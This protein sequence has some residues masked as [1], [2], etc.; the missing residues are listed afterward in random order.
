VQAFY[1]ALI[2][3]HLKLLL[4]DQI[5]IITLLLS[6]QSWVTPTSALLDVTMYGTST[7]NWKVAVWT[8]VFYLSMN[9]VDVLLQLMV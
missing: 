3:V 8:A 4:A 9:S 7:P 1:F 2:L 6:S 5:N